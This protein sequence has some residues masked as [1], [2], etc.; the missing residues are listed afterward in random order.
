MNRL[1]DQVSRREVTYVPPRRVNFGWIS[2]S[3]QFFR[4]QAD[5]WISVVAV[6]LFAPAI[7]NAFVIYA[8]TTSRSIAGQAL[9][10][11]VDTL[12]HSPPGLLIGLAILNGIWSVFVTCGIHTLAIRQVAGNSVSFSDFTS[13]GSAFG[14]MLVFL[15][16]YTVIVTIGL[17]LVILPGVFVAAMLLPAF[18]LIADGASVRTAVSRSFRAMQHDRASALSLTFVIMV[19]LAGSAIPFGL[20][21]FVTAPMAWIISSLAMRDMIGLRSRLAVVDIDFVPTDRRGTILVPEEDIDPSL[22]DAA[23]E[24][25]GGSASM[26]GEGVSGNGRRTLNDETVDDHDTAFPPAS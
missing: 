14:R 9:D 8:Y 20:G 22:I 25:G 12:L 13:G 26:Q 5:V 19:L 23:Y 6:S 4:S 10:N 3:W 2:E 24:Y 7:L 11:R 17:S 16:F 1:D 18:A 21:L 15:V